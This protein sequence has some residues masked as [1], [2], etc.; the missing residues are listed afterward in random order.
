MD[1]QREMF[2]AVQRRREEASFSCEAV[3]TR[4]DGEGELDETTGIHSHGS[5]TIYEG[6]CL[7]R[8]ALRDLRKVSFGGDQR[9]LHVY[10]VQFPADTELEVL[11]TITVTVSADASLVGRS[12][13]VR[14]VQYDEWQT[15]RR[16]VA[17]EVR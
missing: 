9:T 13:V 17:E 6:A 16:V 7:V 5:D 14:D 10:D 12:L 4:R 15:V 8:P 2:L 11:D 3:V 1:A